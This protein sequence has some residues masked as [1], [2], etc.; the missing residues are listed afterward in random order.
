MKAGDLVI[1]N[2]SY[3]VFAH[4]VAR[5][6]MGDGFQGVLDDRAS[7][8]REHDQPMVLLG[9]GEFPRCNSTGR[10]WVQV[11]WGTHRLWCLVD[12]LERVTPC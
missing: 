2:R 9:P 5:S 4:V 6:D 12:A 11:L 7:Y 3:P 10:P 1:L 8:E